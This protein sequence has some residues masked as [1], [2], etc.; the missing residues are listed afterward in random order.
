MNNQLSFNSMKNVSLNYPRKEFYLKHKTT[1]SPEDFTK[2][3][4]NL[5]ND[6]R[7]VPKSEKM[8]TPTLVKECLIIVMLLAQISVSAQVITTPVTVEL[9]T[10]QTVTYTIAGS[11]L[12]EMRLDVSISSNDANLTIYTDGIV[13][14]DNLDIPQPGNHT[15]ITYGV[16]ETQ[17]E[18]EFRFEAIGGGIT[19]NSFDLQ[20]VEGIFLPSF[21]DVTAS[22]GLDENPSL[23][24]GGPSIA[25]VNNDGFYDMI[26]NNH[27][28][29]SDAL[30]WNN[31]DGTLTRHNQN[32]SLWFMMD[33]H[34][35]A[36]GDYDNDGDLDI[37]NTLGGG[38]GTN[39]QPPVFYKNENG[40]FVRSDAS[41]G[42]TSGARGRSPRWVDMDLDGDLDLILINAAGIN[43][44]SGAQHIFYRNKGDGTFETINVDGIENAAGERVLVTDLNNDF[45]DDLIVFS[46]V[47]V[48]LG[49]GDF[50]YTNVSNEWG[51]GSIINV[52]AAE[53]FDY[54]NDGDMDIYLA[55]GEGYFS[56]AENNT[57]NIFP[58]KE[59]GDFRLSGST[60]TDRFNFEAV[61]SIT[62]SGYDYVRR[63]GYDGGFPIF[64]GSNKSSNTIEVKEG[65]LDIS[66]DAADGWPES[67]A[68]NGL[69]IGHMGN[70]QWQAEWVRND[71][72]YWSIHFTIEGMTSFEPVG[73]TPNNHHFDDILLR[74]EGDR[75]TNVSINA[76]LPV[77]GNHWGVTSGDLN[78]DGFEDLYVHRFGFLRNRISDWMLVN[79]GQ[80]GFYPMTSH[81]AQ[82]R[83]ASNHGDGG[84]A[85]DFDN[86]GS[87]DILN[88]DDEYGV[89]HLYKNRGSDQHNH[90]LVKVGYAPISNVD[91]ISA[92]VTVTTP[93]KTYKKRVG[94]AGES[95]SQSLMNIVHFGLGQEENIEHIEVRYRD[96][97][98]V[99]IEDPVVNGVNDT[100]FVTPS[101]ITISPEN[102][103]I[104]QG[105]GVTIQLT[106]DI[107]PVNA[108]KNVIWQSNDPSVAS[109]DENG[110]VSGHLAGQSTVITATTELGNLQ[111]S[112]SV[113]VVEWFPISVASVNIPEES[114]EL[115]EGNTTVLMK[116]ITPPDA[117]NQQVTWESS[118]PSITTV[119]ENGVLTGVSAGTSTVTVTTEDG[120]FQ[121]QV[122]VTVLENIAPSIAFDDQTTYTTTEYNAGDV[123]EVTVNYHAGSGNE[124]IAGDNGG[125]KFW[126]REL[127]AD[128][129]PVKDYIAVDP[130]ALGTQSGT[131]TVNIDLTNAQPNEDLPEGNF[132]WLW[133]NFHTSADNQLI[134]VSVPGIQIGGRVVSVSDIMLNPAELTIAIGE[135][136]ALTATILPSDATDAAL[137][138][139]TNNELVAIVDEAGKVTAVAAGEAVISATT[140][141][142]GFTASSTVTVPGPPLVLGNSNEISSEISFH[143]NPVEDSLIIKGLKTSD[144]TLMVF[145]TGGKKVM[146]KSIKGE[147][148][149]SLSKL[150][151]GNYIFSITGSGVSKAFRLV[152]E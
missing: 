65:V 69:Y 123:M 27:N 102:F 25:D 105:N 63:G 116:E 62:I 22:V 114:M 96:G 131:S 135:T 145:T 129:V 32:L 60:G 23:K 149:I 61:G 79:N 92:L 140:T 73:W 89:W 141:D 119:S 59:R 43:G 137:T 57:V 9:L 90:T 24:Y 134:E 76:N 126:L 120:N 97:E 100:D 82:N 12:K 58:L 93:T 30:F 91:P 110:M 109:V 26:L 115:F 101:S 19:I 112:V 21:A 49:N 104:R 132:Y 46:P 74:N 72:I 2:P 75:F 143:P 118:G 151:N 78:N 31:G 17:G 85:F 40:S 52:Q 29:E 13:V 108:N 28:D 50:T 87:V 86:D 54:D 94:S 133:V 33:L 127:T 128:W 3:S 51:V 150:E 71:N 122:S 15:I 103:D 18:V 83:G 34:G 37:I 6:F 48:W 107:E 11:A 1:P 47:S 130:S 152:K 38:N 10:P 124:V 68:E 95:H 5:K 39:P 20:D 144:Y 121:D 125:I 138:W 117:D 111:A 8:S 35:S 53:D 45:I 70:G 146:E 55:R 88:G 16:F 147:Q 106:A 142:G 64:L 81:A 136:A 139:S 66:I 7:Q 80:G 14:L 56:V 67:R 113:N 41:V 42:I 77:G 4:E 44:N 148:E 36:A 99:L 98:V 84:A